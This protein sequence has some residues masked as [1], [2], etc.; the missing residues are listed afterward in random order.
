VPPPKDAARVDRAV[1]VFAGYTM[2]EE[3]TLLRFA[4]EYFM[5]EGEIAVN[6]VSAQILYSMGPHKAHKF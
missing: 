2:L 3:S 6:G 1:R 4:Y 5:P